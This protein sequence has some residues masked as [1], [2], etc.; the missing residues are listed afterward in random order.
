V[1]VIDRDLRNPVLVH[2]P[3]DNN[4]CG[5]TAGELIEQLFAI[6]QSDVAGLSIADNRRPSDRDASVAGQLTCH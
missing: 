2:S 4:C 5:R 1:N 6:G 3:R